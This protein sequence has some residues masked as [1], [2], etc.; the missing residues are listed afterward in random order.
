MK[1]NG[2]KKLGTAKAVHRRKFIAFNG[3]IRK[4]AQGF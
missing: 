2:I 3:F 4:D 1:I